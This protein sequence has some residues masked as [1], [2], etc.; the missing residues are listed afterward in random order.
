MIKEFRKKYF[1]LSNFYPCTVNYNGITYSTSEA[2]YQAQKT[3]DNNE[4][5]RI[6]KLDAKHAKEEGRKLKKRDDWKEVKVDLMYEICRAKF[7]Q[8]PDLTKRLLDTGNKEL[9]EGNDWNDTFWGVCNGEGSNNLGK[10]LMRI[11]NVI[12]QNSK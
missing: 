11:R 7:T 10:T 12:S 5:I 3:L 1:F 9:V 4:R 2:A 8:N 6:S